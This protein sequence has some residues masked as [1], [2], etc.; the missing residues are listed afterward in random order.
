MN[1]TKSIAQHL[2]EHT[3]VDLIPSMTLETAIR[4]HKKTCQKLQAIKELNDIK[5]THETC[6]QL[7]F[8]RINKLKPK[9]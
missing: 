3:K 1:S 7:L 8:N 6:E 9:E 2:K 4:E 5:V